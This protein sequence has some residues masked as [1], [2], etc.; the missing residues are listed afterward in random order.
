MTADG[1][2]RLWVPFETVQT[3]VFLMLTPEGPVLY[4][5]ATTAQDVET[6]ILPALARMG[7]SPGRLHAIVISHA[8]GDHCGGLSALLQRAPQLRVYALDPQLSPGA[9]HIPDDGEILF[10]CLQALYLPGHTSDC[11]GLYDRRNDLLLTADAL[12]LQGIDRYGCGVSLPDEY[13][14]T[15]DKIRTLSPHILLTSHSYAPYGEKAVGDAAVTRYLDGCMNVLD[16]IR[17]FI[18]VCPHQDAE[19]ITAAFRAQHPQRPLL[20]VSTVR[21]LQ[22][23]IQTASDKPARA[24]ITWS[25]VE[26]QML[27]DLWQQGKSIED[28]AARLDRTP[29]AIHYRLEL[30]GLLPPERSHPSARHR[31]WSPQH[32]DQLTQL[33]AGGCPAEEIAARL[34]YSVESI[35]ARLFYLGLA[36]DAPVSLRKNNTQ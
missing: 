1:L 29:N 4:D 5:C 33:H 31:L 30:F 15:I 2:Y 21:A 22:H 27:R 13:A 19:T 9:V 8:H 35:R 24:G 18:S 12:Q 25:S 20:P 6:L 28:I 16:E 23:S 17:A 14:A 26:K 32:I 7:V 3:S 11:L 34:G 36:K 10:G